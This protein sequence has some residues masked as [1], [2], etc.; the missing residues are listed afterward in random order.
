[1]SQLV[2]PMSRV[3]AE[4]TPAARREVPR[5]DDAAGEAR[6]QQLSRPAPGGVGA[7][8]AAVRRQQFQRSALQR[9]IELG[10]DP[11]T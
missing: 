3:N 4:L 6:E 7:E 2:P 8:E 1:M 5:A 11:S 10:P 9:P